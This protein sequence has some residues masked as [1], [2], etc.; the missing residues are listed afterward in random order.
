[1]DARQALLLKTLVQMAWADQ[2]LVDAEKAL[3]SRVLGELGATPE[4]IVS[5]ESAPEAVNLEQLAQTLPGQ[6]ERL[7]AM[8][9]LLKVAFV[10][11]TL[12]FEEFDLVGRLAQA[13]GID[14]EQL[15]ALRQQAL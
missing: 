6:A 9:L 1:M 3:L 13:L 7:E 8:R 14:E 5:L 15:E 4:E 10:D 11:D 2:K 12:T